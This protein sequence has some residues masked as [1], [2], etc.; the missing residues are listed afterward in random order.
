MASKKRTHAMLS[1][2]FTRYDTHRFS[3][4]INALRFDEHFATRK[5]ASKRPIDDEL[6][7]SDVFEI[8]A[9]RPWNSLFSFHAEV[10]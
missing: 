10:G 4:L 5:I 6:M 7:F 9:K 8:L 1:T 3:S 2:L